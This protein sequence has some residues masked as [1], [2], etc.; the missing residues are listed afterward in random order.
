MA[1]E[2]PYNLRFPGQYYQT[3]TG[4]NYNYYR[5]YDPLTGKYIESDP[6]GLQA[7]SYSTYG[8]AADDPVALSDPLGLYVKICSRWLGKAQ[9]PA[10]GRWNPSATTTSMSVDSSLASTLLQVQIRPGDEES[11]RGRTRQMAADALWSAAAISLMPMCWLPLKRSVRQPIAP[12][13]VRSS[14]RQDWSRR[15]QGPATAN[16]G[17]GMSLRRRSRTIWLTSTAQRALSNSEWL[18]QFLTGY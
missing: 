1:S 4:L 8:Y 13:Q 5:D 11:L 17:H 12:S 18:Q 15:L 3:E 10:T 14:A 7:E 2:F 16:H 6:I 9:N